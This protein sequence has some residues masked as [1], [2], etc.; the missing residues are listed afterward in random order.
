MKFGDAVLK[1]KY[2]DAA[3]TRKWFNPVSQTSSSG[4]LIGRPWEIF[5]AQ[6]VTVDG[7]LIEIYTKGGDIRTYHAIMAFIPDYDLVVAILLSGGGT[8]GFDVLTIFSQLVQ[9]LLPGI[10]QAGKSESEIAYG[11]TYADRATNSTIT[12]NLDDSPGF[13]ISPWVVR[14]VD[15]LRTS[16]GI[17]LPPVPFPPPPIDAP[18]RFRLYPMRAVSDSQTSWRMVAASGTAEEV[19][20]FEASFFWPMA[21]C[22]TWGGLDRFTNMLQSQ[23]HF[24]FTVEDG[25]ATEVELVGY[26]IVLTREG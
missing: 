18:A 2:L 12:L 1:N 16:Q 13:D 20:G 3:E 7:R 24:V 5:R 22:I 4:T 14:G 17:D 15:V 21:T 26:C 9:T 25:K 6:N 8:S 23:D 11:G 10:E 19:A